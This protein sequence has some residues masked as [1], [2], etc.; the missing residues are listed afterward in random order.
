MFGSSSCDVSADTAIG[1]GLQVRLAQI[2]VVGRCFLRLGA[3]IGLDAVEQPH[4]LPVIAHVRGETVRNDDLGLCIDSDLRIVALDITV[5]GQEN[6][7]VRI[8]EVTLRFAVGLGGRRR[9]P[10]AVLLATFGDA[11]FLGWSRLVNGNGVLRPLQRT[12]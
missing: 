2:A 5:L 8:G 9:W 10:L 1:Q 12:N 7:A 3:E 6:A 4:E 11:P